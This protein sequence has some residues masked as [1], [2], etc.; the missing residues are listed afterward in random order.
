MFWNS[1]R[2]YYCRKKW[3]L[4]LGILTV[5]FE[6][7]LGR[8]SLGFASRTRHSEE[9]HLSHQFPQSVL[10]E[11]LKIRGKQIAIWHR[12]IDWGNMRGCARF[13]GGV[14]W[15]FLKYVLCWNEKVWNHPCHNRKNQ[16]NNVYPLPAPHSAWSW[17]QH[18]ESNGIWESGHKCNN[19]GRA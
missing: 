4:H 14:V 9:M 5:S 18:E 6:C 15:F 16:T 19:P 7:V 1:K 13:F 10:I 3:W 17:Q 8:N 11:C 12:L 2:I